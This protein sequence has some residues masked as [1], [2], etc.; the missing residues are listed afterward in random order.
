MSKRI[1]CLISDEASV[2]LDML[3]VKHGLKNNDDAIE[4]VIMKGK[5]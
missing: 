1:N 5:C 4:W 3:K 2:K